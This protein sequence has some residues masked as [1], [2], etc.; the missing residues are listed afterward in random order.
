MFKHLINNDAVPISDRQPSQ[1]RAL[2]S[3]ELVAIS[4]DVEQHFRDPS[5]Q[6]PVGENEELPAF[7]IADL[8]GHRDK[9]RKLWRLTGD[10]LTLGRWRIVQWCGNRGA[11]G[12]AIVNFSRR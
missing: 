12:G 8:M 4:D 9:E 7:D 2:S 6:R 5:C 10:P 3:A 1:N 11:R